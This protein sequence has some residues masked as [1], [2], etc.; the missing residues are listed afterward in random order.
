MTMQKWRYDAISASSIT[1][2]S[3]EKRIIL[4]EYLDGTVRLATHVCCTFF[5][6]ARGV[7]RWLVYPGIVAILRVA[8]YN[9]FGSIDYAGKKD[10]GGDAV[11]SVTA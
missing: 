3:T 9:G 11:R 5:R 8:N 2:Q 6:I 1:H 7:A 4:Y 10:G